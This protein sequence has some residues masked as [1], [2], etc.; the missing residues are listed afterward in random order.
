MISKIKDMF[1]SDPLPPS[2]PTTDAMIQ[3]LEALKEQ[4]EKRAETDTNAI[5]YTMVQMD[6]L[7]NA[8]MKDLKD[9]EASYEAQKQLLTN[10]HQHTIGELETVVS[11]LKSSKVKSTSIALTLRTQLDI[12]KGC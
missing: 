9:L 6:D 3:Q 12:L 10:E 1:Y 11:K 2:I 8:H 7:T 5:G 4:A